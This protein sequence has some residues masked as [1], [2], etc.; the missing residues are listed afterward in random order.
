M[1]RIVQEPRGSSANP[2]GRLEVTK[3]LSRGPIEDSQDRVRAYLSQAPLSYKLCGLLFF[4]VC[5]ILRCDAVWSRRAQKFVALVSLMPAF[6][7]KTWVHNVEPTSILPK[8]HQISIKT[9]Q[10]AITRRSN[11]GPPSLRPLPMSN[12]RINAHN[13]RGV[14]C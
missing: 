14:S 5:S 8:L 9:P 13:N 2:D 7:L 6:C 11:V 12:S 10:F 4:I 1:P 3:C